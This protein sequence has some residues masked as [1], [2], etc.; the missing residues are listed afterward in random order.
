[1]PRT[2]IDVTQR[3][4]EQ[5]PVWPGDP[6]VHVTRVS[7]DLPMLS[8]L[9]M[10]LPCRHSRGRSG[11]LPA[12]GAGVDVLPLDVSVGPAWVARLVGQ[13]PLDG[14]HARRDRDP[15]RHGSTADSL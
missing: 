10:S 8:G 5:L 9:S 3:I 15:A 7:D 4:S 1:M 6:P 2:L 12:G 13:A 14:Q 11:A